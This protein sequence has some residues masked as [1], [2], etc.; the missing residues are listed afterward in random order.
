MENETGGD[1]KAISVDWPRLYVCIKE[2]ERRC[3]WVDVSGCLQSVPAVHPHY[4]SFP[5]SVIEL[6]SHSDVES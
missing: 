2:K 6:R 3:M 5:R 4:M 1:S